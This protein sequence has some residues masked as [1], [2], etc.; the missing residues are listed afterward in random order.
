MVALFDQ[1]KH[2]LDA[3][4]AELGFVELDRRRRL[5]FGEVLGPG[6][7]LAL[8]LLT[9]PRPMPSEA[10]SARAPMRCLRPRACPDR[11]ANR[12]GHRRRARRGPPCA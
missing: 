10:A 5:G 1:A 2:L 3:S 8:L 4:Y 9:R 6:E 12:P 11:P 7:A